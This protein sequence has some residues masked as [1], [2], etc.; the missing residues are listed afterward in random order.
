MLEALI[1]IATF[2]TQ[3][4]SEKLLEWAIDL[5]NDHLRSA[6]V[7]EK[8]E[9]KIQI[10]LQESFL[11]LPDGIYIIENF[12]FIGFLQDLRVQNELSL[13]MR[14]ADNRARC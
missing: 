11:N 5:R 2:L 4:F 12:D 7:K 14:P 8:I 3:F 6:K 10:V 1:P 13:L 9:S